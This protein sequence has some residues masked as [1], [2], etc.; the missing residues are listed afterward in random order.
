MRSVLLVMICS[1]LVFSCDTDQVY[2]RYTSLGGDWNIEEP[3]VLEIE[4]LDSIKPYNVY[5]TLRND[6]RYSYSNLFL[7]TEMEYPQ[8]R[9]LTDTLEYEM[10][11]PDGSWLGQGFGDVKE[12]ILWYKEGARFRESG[13][14]TFTIK[15]AVRKNGNISGDETLKGITEIG[16]RIEEEQP[17]KN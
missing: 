11:A 8:G 15:H 1:V 14:Y 3:V 9:T 17:Q 5:I 7:I 6:N 2:H 16:L 10:A 12:S 4:E 13:I